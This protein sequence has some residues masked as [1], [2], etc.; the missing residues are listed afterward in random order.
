MSIEDF[1]VG[2][3]FEKE[4]SVSYE[5]VRKFAEIS[6]DWNPAHHDAEYAEKTVFK[7]Q[8]AHGMISVAQFSGIFG[9][10]MPGLGAIWMNQSAT[11][12]A[13]VYLDKPYKAI[14]EVKEVNTEKNV[15]V[16]DTRCEDAE[17]KKVLVGEG[18]LKPIPAKVK[19]KME[20]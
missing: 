19:A 9:M 3:S 16:F 15:V 5:M 12:L 7:K 20:L 10:D 8:I 17:G 18:A 2:D 1:K 4:Y 11:F 13:P 6:G 14:V